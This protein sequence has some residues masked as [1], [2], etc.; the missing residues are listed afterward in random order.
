MKTL[1]V[2]LSLAAV[3][4]APALNAQA[5]TIKRTLLQRVDL[6]N[7]MELVLGIAEIAPGG[8]TGRHTHFGVETG[9]ALSGTSSMEVE[10]EAPRLLRAGESYVIPAGKVHDAKVVGAESARV[11]AVYVVQKGKPLATP[12]Q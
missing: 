10:G 3:L 2:S 8:S 7:N 12:A 11:L 9:Y 1:A 4:L 5:P 6:G